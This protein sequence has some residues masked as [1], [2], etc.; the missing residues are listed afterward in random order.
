MTFQYFFFATVAGY[1]SQALPFALAAGVV[2]AGVVMRVQV[3]GPSP[4]MSG[5]LALTFGA[6]AYLCF[7]A[8]QK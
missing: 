7:S 2:I 4:L 3:F 6:L 8:L 1:F 5:V